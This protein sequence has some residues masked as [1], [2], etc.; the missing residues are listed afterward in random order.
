MS[1]T[2]S[3]RFMVI[4]SD[5]IY[6]DNQA[7]NQTTQSTKLIVRGDHLTVLI[8]AYEPD[9]RLLQLVTEIQSKTYFNILIVND[10]SSS[11]FQAIFDCAE[12]MGC[13]VLSRNRNSGKGYALKTGF[14]YIM[15]ESKERIGVV[16]ADADG[17]HLVDDIIKVANAISGSSLK[18]VLGARKFTGKIP[19]RSAIGNS[20]THTIFSLV[21]GMHISDTQTGL[22][23]FPVSLLPWLIDLEGKRFDYEMN[24]LLFAK[25]AGYGITELEIKTVYLPG[26]RSSHFRTIQDSARVYFP[27][28]KFCFY[29]ITSAFVDYTLLFVFQWMTGNLFVSVVG[30]RVSSSAVNF[31]INRSMVFKSRKRQHKKVTELSYYYILMGILL[32]FNYLLLRFLSENLKINLFWSKILTEITLFGLSFSAQHLFVFRRAQAQN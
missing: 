24:M 10:G 23:G 18:I 19:L 16:T 30:A 2:I 8:P 1:S 15:K 13:V 20:I 25:S 31:T 12:N 21:S 28:F 11:Q 4:I 7:S 26:N 5:I 17:H 32:I 14:S 9:E 27:F 29:G 3:R 22:R 6:I